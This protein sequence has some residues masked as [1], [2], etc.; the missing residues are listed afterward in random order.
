MKDLEQLIREKARTLAELAEATGMSKRQVF[1]TLQRLKVEQVVN[2]DKRH[3]I[4]FTTYG[5]EQ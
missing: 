4:K 5:G 2:R 3:P 1:E